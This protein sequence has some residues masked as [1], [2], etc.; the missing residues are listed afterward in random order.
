MPIN[1]MPDAD[2]DMQKCCMNEKK[3]LKTIVFQKLFVTLQNP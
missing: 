3:T 1:T 2:L